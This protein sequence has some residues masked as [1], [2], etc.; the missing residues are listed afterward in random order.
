MKKFLL[1]VSWFMLYAVFLQ[2]VFPVVVDPFNVFHADN[3][4]YTG[5]EANRNYVKMNYILKHPEKFS[6]FIFGSS[7]VGVIHTEK[8]PAHKIYNMTY[9]MGLPHE[10]LVN[11]KTFHMNDIHPAI[12]YLGLDEISYKE[13]PESHIAGPLRCPYEF[14]Q[15]RHYFYQLYLRPMDA[16]RSIPLRLSGKYRESYETFYEY[17]WWG[18]YNL[19]GEKPIKP[20]PENFRKYSMTDLR[21]VIDD[22]KEILELCERNGTKVVVFTNPTYCITYTRSAKRGYIDFLESLAYVTE[23]WNFSGLNDITLSDDNYI[24][25]SHYKAEVGDIMIDIMCNGKSYPQL[26]SQGFGVKVSSENARDF[27]SMLRRQYQDYTE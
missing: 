19:R 27:I 26:Q 9:S 22:V 1:K 16:L 7:R 3:I 15:D 2:F 4:R 12:I 14:L 11:L 17:G 8:I 5:S 23:F 13:T 21:R 6:G 10:N 20:M 18:D 25:A 24:D